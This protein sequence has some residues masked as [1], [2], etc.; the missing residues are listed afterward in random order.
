MAV[1]IRGNSDEIRY[2]N[3]AIHDGDV[4][5]DMPRCTAQIPEAEVG[6]NDQERA[7]DR[8]TAGDSGQ[9]PDLGVFVQEHELVLRI[10]RIRSLNAYPGIHIFCVGT[11]QSR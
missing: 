11:C 1:E 10:R 5:E 3:P 7:H 8:E 9:N 4:N 2:S 6:E